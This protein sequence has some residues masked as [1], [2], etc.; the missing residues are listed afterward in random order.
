ME[1]SIEEVKVTADQTVQIN[2]AKEF[3]SSLN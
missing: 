1:D 3:I 2:E